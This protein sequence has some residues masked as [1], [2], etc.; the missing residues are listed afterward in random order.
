[1]TDLLRMS[2]S[3]EQPLA[4][5]LEEMRLARAY[6]NRSEF[7]RDLIREQIVE[8]E[9]EKNEEAIGTISLL[10]DHT[11]RNLSADLTDLQHAH[12]ANVLATTHVHLDH[13]LCAEMIM[14]RGRASV[15]RNMAD[16]L[17]RQKGVLH[18]T[19]SLSSTGSRLGVER[20]HTHH[21]PRVAAARSK[22]GRDKTTARKR[23][24]RPRR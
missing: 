17:R 10:Y 3:I 20:T 7:L 23:G 14:V 21:H 9:W 22:A 8:E 13:D 15:L 1:M 19:L 4:D 11:R 5:R 6:E 24:S 2:F 18:G 16:L 12:H